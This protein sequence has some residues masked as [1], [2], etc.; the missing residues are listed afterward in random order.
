M[1]FAGHGKLAAFTVVYIGPTFMNQ[2]GFDKNNPYLTGVVSLDEGVKIS[3]RLLGFEGHL[4]ADVKIGTP[5]QVEF[6]EIGEGEGAKPQLAFRV[7]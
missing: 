5:M 3:A 1:E 7:D 6:L 2:V 4:P